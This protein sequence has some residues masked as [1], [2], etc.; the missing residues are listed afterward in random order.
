VFAGKAGRQAREWGVER[1]LV[2]QER[3]KRRKPR[4]RSVE[5]TRYWGMADNRRFQNVAMR[6]MTQNMAAVP[7]A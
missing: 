2:I 4:R 6:W 3:S 1:G 7:M 5:P